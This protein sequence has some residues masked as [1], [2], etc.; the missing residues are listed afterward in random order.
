MLSEDS[1]EFAVSNLGNSAKS[2]GDLHLSGAAKTVNPG[3]CYIYGSLHVAA[4]KVESLLN[5]LRRV[6]YVLLEGFDTGSWEELVEKHPLTFLGVMAVLLLLKGEKNLFIKPAGWVYSRF[7]GIEFR[8]DMEYVA[9]LA[10]EM[11]KNVEFAD[12]SFHEVYTVRREAYT[13]LYKFLIFFVVLVASLPMVVMLKLAILLRT[14]LAFLGIPPSSPFALLMLVTYA[15]LRAL[16]INP[17]LSV[18][19]SIVALLA[20]GLVFVDRINDIRD[21]K[22]V[23]RVRELVASGHSVLVVR[24]KAHVSYILRELMAMGIPCETFH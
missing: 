8:G 19:V 17:I 24:G 14:L 20:C 11:G 9:R 6:D 16:L 7:H 15:T 12:S 4:P 3:K 13:S 2:A 22:V 18:I 23:N 21:S 5:V 1:V 10:R